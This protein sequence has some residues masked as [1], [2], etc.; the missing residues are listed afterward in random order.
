MPGVPDRPEADVG[1]RD[2]RQRSAEREQERDAAAVR[3][4]RW[5][6][7]SADAQPGCRRREPQAGEPHAEERAAP[8]VQERVDAVGA[9]DRRGLGDLGRRVARA[10]ERVGELGVSGRRAGRRASP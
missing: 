7:A 5:S 6:S 1:A 3:A 2:E 9:A 10:G 4:P 8:F